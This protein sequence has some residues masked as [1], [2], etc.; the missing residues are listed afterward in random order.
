MGYPSM[1]FPI[2]SCFV[3]AKAIKG[4]TIR[5]YW[6]GGGGSFLEINIF[7]WEKWVK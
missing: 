7:G 4:T 5:I 2:F 1:H 6:L 3:K